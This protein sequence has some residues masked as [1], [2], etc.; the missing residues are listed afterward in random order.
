MLRLRAAHIPVSFPD[1]ARGRQAELGLDLIRSGQ[2]TAKT[3]TRP[4]A[5]TFRLREG[6]QSDLIH[7]FDAAGEDFRD[8]QRHD[9]LR[10]LDDSQGLVYVLDPFS[11]RGH[12]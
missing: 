10:F 2:D 7:L 4:V 11:D 6:H 1:E 8:A 3:S 5:I 9:G 12:P